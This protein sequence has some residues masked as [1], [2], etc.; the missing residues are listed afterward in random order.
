MGKKKIKVTFLF[1]LGKGTSVMF[2]ILSLASSMLLACSR[3]SGNICL[4]HL[5]SKFGIPIII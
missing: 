3:N 4:I 5:N 2:I 1:L